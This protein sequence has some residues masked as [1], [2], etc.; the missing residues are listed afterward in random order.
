[1]YLF[2][3]GSRHSVSNAANLKRIEGI[4]DV[5]SSP[6]DRL[7]RG[8]PMRGTEI[9]MR[10]NDAHFAGPGDLFLF[11]SVFDLFLAGL[12]ALNTFTRLTIDEVTTGGTIEWPPRL[13]GQQL[14]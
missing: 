7:M 9:R 12:A 10:L 14:L 5:E 13:G 4:E 6:S 8:V 2:D 3:G 1:M 11:G